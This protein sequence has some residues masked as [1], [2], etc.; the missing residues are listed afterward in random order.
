MKLPFDY[1]NE[2]A[3]KYDKLSLIQKVKEN[4]KWVYKCVCDC[5]N[6]TTKRVDFIKRSL[7]IGRTISCGKCLRKNI[8]IG[9]KFHYL[10]VIKKLPSKTLSNKK[11][12]YWLLEC[13]CGNLHKS[14]SDLLNNGKTKSC[15][16]WCI[17]S[18]S[19][20]RKSEICFLYKTCPKCKK[21]KHHSK[22]GKDKNRRGGLK[23]F[24]RKCV[25]SSK[26]YSKVAM[27]NF[28]RKKRIKQSTPKWIK[29]KDILNIHKVKFELEELV[30]V[31]LNVDHI[32]PLIHKQYCGLTVPYNLQ[33][34][35]E[36]FNLSK[37][38]RVNTTEVSDLLKKSIN[39]K[40]V[41]IHKSVTELLN[42]SQL[43]KI[44]TLPN[45]V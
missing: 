5:G 6:K 23:S 42:D 28:L 35:T 41:I 15:G 11:R 18:R 26:D 44:K 16:C 39:Y 33:I 4:D 13:K 19:I 17:E 24:C 31:K 29:K 14:T 40:N 2:L 34:T 27:N 43:K 36:Q 45:T 38:N 32:F 12:G 25:Y 3:I 37:Q 20:K 22:F 7:R 8:Q 10:T 9:D 30:K 1:K 21:E